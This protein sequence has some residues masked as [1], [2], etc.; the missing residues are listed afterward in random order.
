MAKKSAKNILSKVTEIKSPIKIVEPKKGTP[1]SLDA[2]V[3]TLESERET[4]FIASH[5]STPTLRTRPLPTSTP[6]TNEPVERPVE[7]RAREVESARPAKYTARTDAEQYTA[8]SAQSS[9]ARYTVMH[10][11][12]K[13]DERLATHTRIASPAITLGQRQGT[14]TLSQERFVGPS[15]QQDPF[16]LRPT[17]HDDALD[18]RYDMYRE[19][20]LQDA[21]KPRRVRR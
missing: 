10:G 11:E 17:G 6:R 1:E 4:S 7:P 16:T 15:A 5:A 20:S 3:E 2:E 9:T 19:E 13:A 18:R 14:N 21:N 12:A 8:M